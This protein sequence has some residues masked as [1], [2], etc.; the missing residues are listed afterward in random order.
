WAAAIGLHHYI[1]KVDVKEVLVPLTK[2]G[3]AFVRQEAM[4]ALGSALGGA[5]KA[6]KNEPLNPEL[7][8]V[9]V[10]ALADKAAPVRVEAV[11]S[12]GHAVENKVAPAVAKLGNDPDVN[13]RVQVVKTLHTLND[14]AT[15]P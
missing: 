11:R 1:S 13:V 8:G 7:V 6:K 5:R 14:P 4:A 12:L 3:S 9:L 10:E 2:D 15:L